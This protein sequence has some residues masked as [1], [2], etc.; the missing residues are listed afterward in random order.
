MSTPSLSDL[1]IH[2]RWWLALAVIAIFGAVF[3]LIQIHRADQS[4]Q[5]YIVNFSCRARVGT[6]PNVLVSGLVVKERTQTVLVRVLGPTLATFGIQDA[7]AD[8][9]LQVVHQGS[10]REVGRNDNWTDLRHPRLTGDLRELRPKDRR[11]PVLILRLEPGTYS[12]VVEGRNQTQG[13]ALLEVFRV[14]D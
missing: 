14:K 5:T 2:L 12:L 6:G 7:L 11:E 1:P 8:P 13:V 10:G 4:R 3:T 9:V